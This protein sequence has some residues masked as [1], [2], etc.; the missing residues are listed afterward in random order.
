MST[1]ILKTAPLLFPITLDQVKKFAFINDN[2]YNDLIT[3]LIPAAVS[4]IEN[5]TGR[6]L[7]DQTWDVYYDL[8]A[9]TNS[10][11]LNT[12]NVTAIN[13][14]NIFDRD[15]TA[16]LIDA[17]DYRLFNNKLIFNS[18]FNLTRFSFRNEQAMQ[19]EVAAGFGADSAAQP[20]DIQSA[21]AQL[22]IYWTKTGSSSHINEDL[23]T[24]P[25][26]VDSKI[27]KYISWVGRI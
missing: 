23:R 20:V 13:E 16:T 17:S 8:P 26:G 22:I 19:V 2:N 1:K 14:V 18:D 21:L 11:N 9:I 5:K 25:I 27:F 10:V 4:Y 3:S 6:V 7:V 15:N 24:V 12:L